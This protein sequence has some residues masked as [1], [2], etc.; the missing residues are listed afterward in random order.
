MPLS[1][2][3]ARVARSPLSIV[4]AVLS[5][6]V[7]GWGIFQLQEQLQAGG[8]RVYANPS[9]IPET[10][11]GCQG[12]SDVFPL[13]AGTRLVWQRE[14]PYGSELQREVGRFAP[15]DIAAVHSFYYPLPIAFLVT[16]FAA[17]PYSW[18]ATL[19][20]WVM[21]FGFAALLGVVM[22]FASAGRIPWGVALGGSAWLVAASAMFRGASYLQQPAL[23]LAVLQVGL[24]LAIVRGGW[25]WAG[26]LAALGLVKPQFGFLPALVALAVIGWHDR[27]RRGLMAFGIT[28]AA[29]ALLSFALVPSWVGDFRG[30]VT[31]YASGGSRLSVAQWMHAPSSLIGIGS[32]LVVIALVLGAV[33]RRASDVRSQDAGSMRVDLAMLAVGAMALSLLVIPRLDPLIG[34][35]DHL[36]LLIPVALLTGRAFLGGATRITFGVIALLVPV[37]AI[38]AR[39][40]LGFRQW[41]IDLL[42]TMQEVIRFVPPQGFWYGNQFGDYYLQSWAQITVLGLALACAAPGIRFVAR[43]IRA[44]ARGLTASGNPPASGA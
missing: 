30:N 20:T 40:Y 10:L 3:T 43:A 24:C 2:R 38:L 33:R 14:T 15:P 39:D 13:L 8:G 32:V 27:T 37:W 28:V 41:G 31:D 21:T 19:F 12:R 25:R 42:L 17:M 16:P 29:M 23:L 18:G 1:D 44:K 11:P 35:Y 5:V 9:C 34:P 7:L 26:V 36:Y 4:L 22:R 6:L